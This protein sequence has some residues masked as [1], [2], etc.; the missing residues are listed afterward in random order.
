MTD[1]HWKI[2]KG[3]HIKNGRYYLVVKNQWIALSR[4]DEGLRALR[5]ALREVPIE[6]APVTIGELLPIYLREA[7]ITEVTREEYAR[8]CDA[9][10]MHHFG[11]MPIH[12][13]QQTHVATYLEKRKRDGA[14]VMG[15]R[16]RAVLS[17]A[18]E[19]AMRQGW[20]RT[21]PCHGIK[22]NKERPRTRYP[23]DAEFLEAFEVAPGPVQD[24]LAIGL[25]TGAREG[26]LRKMKRTDLT[27]DGIVIVE[28]KTELTTG[29]TRVIA[30]SEALRYFVRRSLERQ[31]EVAAKV[32]DAKKHRRARPVSDHVLVNK[33]NEPW[34][35]WAIQS[36]LKRIPRDGWHFH[37]LRRK[38]AS[39]AGH[40][41]LGH[42]TDMLNVYVTHQRVK[43]LR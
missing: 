7:E 28:G 31:A 20:A 6:R 13:M 22:R 32:A 17:G 21:N 41:I 15:N 29:K 30:W 14:P 34:S 26:D 10:L 40:N 42:G 9:R 25:L 1:S 33:F 43:A 24:F 36:A 12:S 39:E 18:F 35:E 8:I 16:E 38:A 23:S 11:R 3:V 19:Y 4:V 37:D 2:P 27:P 5:A